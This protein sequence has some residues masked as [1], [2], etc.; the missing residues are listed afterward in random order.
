[1]IQQTQEQLT[2]E[3]L[4]FSNAVSGLKAI[5]HPSR[6][7]ILCSLVRTEMTVGD[8]VKRLGLSQSA[9]SQHLGKMKAAGILEDRRSGNHVFYGLKDEVYAELVTTICRIYNDR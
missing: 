3:R 9:V 4:N 7:H 8:L 1:M 6:L 2:A 5:A